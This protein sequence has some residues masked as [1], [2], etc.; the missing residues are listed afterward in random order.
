MKPKQ[1]FCITVFAML[2]ICASI[3]WFYAK[4]N[5]AYLSKDILDLKDVERLFKDEGIKLVNKGRKK[6]EFTLQQ[7]HSTVYFIENDEFKELDIYVFSSEEERKAAFSEYDDKVNKA[8][9]SVLYH[10]VYEAKN[11][12]VIAIIVP[13]PSKYYSIVSSAIE[14]MKAH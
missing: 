9:D 5:Q 8:I 1:A 13:S 14:K 11:I 10:E 2:I 12:I 6:S 7:K 3:Y 4:E